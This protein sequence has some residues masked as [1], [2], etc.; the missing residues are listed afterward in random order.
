MSRANTEI[1]DAIAA[2]KKTEETEET[3]KIEVTLRKVIRLYP[4]LNQS[5]LMFLH[6]LVHGAEL[7]A[8]DLVVFDLP[9]WNACIPFWE[10][11]TDTNPESGRIALQLALAN[12]RAVSVFKKPAN[13]P[14]CA[15]QNRVQKNE[16]VR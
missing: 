8:N 11:G 4:A 15:R 3:I 10:N 16:Q 5:V 14:E 12:R 7:N 1:S 6:V 13:R 2:R 9:K